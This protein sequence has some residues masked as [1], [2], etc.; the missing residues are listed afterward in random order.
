VYADNVETI[1][2]NDDGGS[3]MDC[4]KGD[5]GEHVQKVQLDK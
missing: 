5:Q 3:E 2:D 1:Q 4:P